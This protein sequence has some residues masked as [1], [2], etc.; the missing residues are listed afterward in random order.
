MKKTLS[1]RT[2]III[3]M[4]LLLVL[5]NIALIMSIS[6]SKIFYMLDAESFR[7]FNNTAS[8]RMQTL[9]KEIGKVIS[10]VSEDAKLLSQKI[11][12]YQKLVFD[13][14]TV[15]ANYMEELST[16]GSE[17][18]MHL[19]QNNSISGAFFILTPQQEQESVSVY[20]RNPI[21]Q[22]LNTGHSLFT[23][24]IGNQQISDFYGLQKSTSWQPKFPIPFEEMKSQEYFHKPVHASYLNSS[25]EISFGFWSTHSTMLTHLQPAFYY[26]LPLLNSK[27]IP[28]GIIGIEIS[29]THFSQHFL[30]KNDLSYDDSF[31]IISNINGNTLSLDWFVTGRH[32][33]NIYL[34]E[35]KQISMTPT[36]LSKNIYETSLIG[37]GEVYCFVHPLR[38]YPADSP[39]SQELWSLVSFVPKKTLHEG[40][41]NVQKTLAISL[42]VTSLL[43]FVALI[44]LAFVSTRRITALSKYVTGLNPY[45]ELHLARTGMREIDDLSVAVET[46]NRRVI[47]SSKTTSK[48]LE[49]SLLPIGGYEINYSLGRVNVTEYINHLLDLPNAAQLTVEEWEVYYKQ[50]TAN[51]ES[52]YENIYRFLTKTDLVHVWLRILENDDHDGKI[53]VVLDVTKEIEEHQRLLH[54]LDFDSM[55]HLYNRKAFKR[56][57]NQKILNHPNEVGVMIFSDLDNLKYINDTFGHETGDRLI[58]RASEMFGQF[59]SLGGIVSRIS[60]D[61]FAIYLHGYSSKEEAM[62]V[63]NSQFKKFE[64]YSLKSPDGVSHRIRSSSGL[65]WYPE[66]STNVTD[67][68]KLSDFAM[69]EAKHNQKGVLYEFNPEAYKSK[70]FL[71]DNR[72]AIHR[73]IDERLIHFHYQPIVSLQTGNIYAYECLMRSSMSEF[74]TPSEIL[75]VATSQSQLAQLERLVFQVAFESIE[76]QLD[77]IGQAQIFINSI[78][79]HLL[80]FK[81]F[82]NFKKKYRSF[83]SQVVIEVT[84]RE[85]NTLYNVN[86]RLNSLRKLGLRFAIDDFGNGYSSEVRFLS[87]NPDILKI[88]MM[89]IK[90]ISGDIDKQKLVENLIS[91]C[92]SKNIMLIAEGVEN[93]N[94]LAKIIEMGVD[95]VQ[96]YYIGKP[97][98]AIEKISPKVK[99]EILQLHLQ[100]QK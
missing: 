34:P 17:N 36:V 61:E 3:L 53:G 93:K 73:L 81:E 67:L 4:T 59:S 18:L 46:L 11:N 1:L 76:Q 39:F 9:N 86:E 41:F 12:N 56:E 13:S 14:S 60:G 95:F 19:L 55:T 23:L 45:Q 29:H 74:K 84:E 85:S 96:G 54:E 20:I 42:G 98:L 70:A 49:L 5:Q 28:I 94:D 22:N 37:L 57:V 21:N 92:H 88:D 47:D 51:P 63:V 26:T 75:S 100:F 79:S 2:K 89:L 38:I 16:I 72:E 24:E 10:N 90:G 91:F 99:A 7:F 27:R 66:H 30:P 50:L 35:G 80:G 97:T 77:V 62:Q 25:E 6:S 68:L 8:S 15:P 44:F 31:Y 58:L 78:P 82:Q 83:F 33:A 40:A 65:A 43:T 64:L 69:Y 52:D 48:I 71:L 32:I 87:V